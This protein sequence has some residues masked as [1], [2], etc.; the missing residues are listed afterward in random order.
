[1]RRLFPELYGFALLSVNALNEFI[2]RYSLNSNILEYLQKEINS[3]KLM[4]QKLIY[5][6]FH[7]DEGLYSFEYKLSDDGKKSHIKS[8]GSLSICG[9]GYLVDF[10]YASLV[11]KQ[12]VIEFTI[13]QGE[14]EIEFDVD[15]EKEQI[16]IE[17]KR[18][19]RE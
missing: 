13:P 17:F 3:N 4:E 1:M 9:I 2:T 5:P 10:T 12:K 16:M 7:I 11:E 14:Y 15:S 18:V 6:I 19:N 8:D